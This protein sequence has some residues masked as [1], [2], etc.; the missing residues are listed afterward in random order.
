MGSALRLVA[1]GLVSGLP[2]SLGAARLIQH[3][4]FGVS[5]AEPAV[6]AVAATL[7]SVVAAVAAFV[8]ARRATKVDAAVAL[9]CE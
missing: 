3:Q 8:P 9:R 2:G 6:V 4:L 7:L 1:A 5:A